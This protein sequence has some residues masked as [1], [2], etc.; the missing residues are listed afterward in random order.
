MQ[1]NTKLDTL[2]REIE[3]IKSEINRLKQE[4]KPSSNT[5]FQ[6]FETEIASKESNLMEKNK[7]FSNQ[8]SKIQ[9]LE[10]LKSIFS[11]IARLN[12]SEIGLN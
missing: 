9:K 6:F 5:H 3:N 1:E 4:K 12:A 8:Q 7:E 10:E 2:N 11:V